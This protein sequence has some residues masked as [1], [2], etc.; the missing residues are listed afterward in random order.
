[1]TKEPFGETEKIVQHDAHS[2][3]LAE[4]D[5][6][7]LNEIGKESGGESSTD[8]ETISPSSILNMASSLMPSIPPARSISGPSSST[9]RPA[10]TAQP[11]PSSE[12]P[13]IPSNPVEAK[14][15][16][17]SKLPARDHKLTDV[18]RTAHDHI[19]TST[20]DW[21]DA[22]TDALPKV[23]PGQAD[24]PAVHYGKDVVLDMAGYHNRAGEVAED[25]SMEHIERSSVQSSV[26][27][28]FTR[29]LLAA[30]GQ[31]PVAPT[32]PTLSHHV[33]TDPAIQLTSTP[34]QINDQEDA[35][36]AFELA[37]SDR[38]DEEEERHFDRGQSEPPPDVNRT[39]RGLSR[40]LHGTAIGPPVGANPRA[41]MDYAWDWGTLPKPP[42]H[43]D[44]VDEYDGAMERSNSGPIPV[45]SSEDGSTPPRANTSKVETGP[46]SIRLGHV[47][48]NPYIFTLTRPNGAPHA[49]E[50]A[51]CGSDT[52]AKDGIATVSARRGLA[53]ISA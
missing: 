1:M 12:S 42:P 9:S 33:Q 31:V 34:G 51:L 44:D 16:Q 20:E 19:P 47:D 38:D 27:D 17:P 30:I 43:P 52:F 11:P 53:L 14:P 50:L 4:V 39:P 25:S 8:G 22:A 48:H 21:D 5:Y 7:D 49:F 45:A 35:A 37:V 26:I 15:G 28:S 29:D 41:V 46:M 6:L 40:P 13:D 23:Q 18:V 32:R 3:E 10:D 2:G 36:S 24:G